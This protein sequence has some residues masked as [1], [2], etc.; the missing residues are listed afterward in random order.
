[1]QASRDTSC[2]RQPVPKQYH[3]TTSASNSGSSLPSLGLLIARSASPGILVKLLGIIF[4]I[5]ASTAVFV[6]T[7]T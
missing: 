3:G 2:A 5:P 4:I 7:G 1:M 6:S